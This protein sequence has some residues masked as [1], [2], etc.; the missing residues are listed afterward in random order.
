M[1]PAAGH[2]VT[3]NVWDLL[4]LLLCCHG[5]KLKIS[6]VIT[7]THGVVME[8]VVILFIIR[9]GQKMN[10]NIIRVESLLM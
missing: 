4:R 1:T 6:L 2:A 9:D 5:I 7:N 8:T 3:F 10:T